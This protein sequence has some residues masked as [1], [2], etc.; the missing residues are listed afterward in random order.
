MTEANLQHRVML[1]AGVVAILGAAPA[2]AHEFWIDPSAGRVEPGAG[3]EAQ[4]RVGTMMKGE[5]YPYISRY[6]T[7]FSVTAGGVTEPVHGIEG[8]IPAMTG[9]PARSGLNVIAHETV[10]FIV[11]HEDWSA[12]RKYLTDEGFPSLEARHLARGLPETGFVERYIRHV[13]ALVQAGPI[14]PADRDVW[15]GMPFE[16]VAEA[17]PYQPDLASLPVRLFWRG[18]P[19]ADW[20]IAVYRLADAATRENLRTDGEGRALVPL[21]PGE[22]LLSSVMLV[23]QEDTPVAWLSHWAALSFEL[24]D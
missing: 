23:E 10:P 11:T 5:P 18:E 9:I 2:A 22:F 3:I 7:R 24:D 17:N 12:F 14:D 6:F 8:D 15:I 4:L 16:I 20:Q 19:L 13:K 1:S 21:S